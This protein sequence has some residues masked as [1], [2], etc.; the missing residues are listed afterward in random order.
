MTVTTSTEALIPDEIARAA[1]LPESYMD[2]KNVTYPAFKW[3]R[4]NNPLGIAQIDGFDPLYLVTKLDDLITIERQPEV[5][6]NGLKNPI[7]NS[8]ADDAF[9]RGLTGGSIRSIDVTP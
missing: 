2:E 4:E 5:F 3:L 6:A 9:I 7:L 1:V 8:Q